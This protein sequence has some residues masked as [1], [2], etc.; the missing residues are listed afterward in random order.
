MKNLWDFTRKCN[1]RGN[2]VPLP[3]YVCIAF[4]NPEMT[5]RIHEQHDLSVRVIGRCVEALVVNNLAANINSRGVKASESELACLSAILG[6]KSDDVKCLLHNPGAIEFTKMVF[7]ALDNF[8]SFTLET[9]PEDI[10][11]VVQKTFDIL[12]QALPAESDTNQTDATMIMFDGQR[13]FVLYSRFQ[14]LKIFIRVIISYDRN[15]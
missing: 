14:R 11:D 15:I 12:S 2:S 5:R 4:A 6:T 9:V 10:P 1:K 3:S 13:E 7:L 8:Y